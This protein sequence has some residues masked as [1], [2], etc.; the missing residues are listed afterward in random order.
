MSYECFLRDYAKE[1]CFCLTQIDKNTFKMNS[2]NGLLKIYFR[3]NLNYL[4]CW[5][6]FFDFSKN[7]TM[8]ELKEMLDEKF[9]ESKLLFYLDSNFNVINRKEIA[10]SETVNANDF[11]DEVEYCLESDFYFPA[12]LY[13]CSGAVVSETK[14]PKIENTILKLKE[15]LE[16]DKIECK[17]QPVYMGELETFDCLIVDQSKTFLRISTNVCGNILRIEKENKDLNFEIYENRFIRL[18]NGQINSSNI[19]DILR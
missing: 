9:K 15:I 11:I 16:K 18:E 2:R 1:N 13:V 8:E 3:D 14:M 17:I 12:K 7:I 4:E 5:G 6:C 10:I 19:E